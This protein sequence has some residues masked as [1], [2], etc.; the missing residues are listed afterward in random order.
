ME[1]A[2]SAD[3]GAATT[4][5]P[6]PWAP[7]QPKPPEAARRTKAPPGPE[8]GA[9]A[10]GGAGQ[11]DTD[12][13]CRIVADRIREQLA[14][15]SRLPLGPRPFTNSRPLTGTISDLTFTVVFSICQMPLF[16]GSP[17]KFRSN[18]ASLTST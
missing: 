14:G 1:F 9:S 17:L 8:R 15:F 11:D 5:L 6:R 10:Q 12:S 16:K 7:P 3:K 13:W 4:I 2:P 18:C